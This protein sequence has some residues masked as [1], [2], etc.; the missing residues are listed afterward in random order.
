M[1][2]KITMVIR[3]MIIIA[4]WFDFYRYRQFHSNVIKTSETTTSKNDKL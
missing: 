3:K 4:L 2:D 1:I